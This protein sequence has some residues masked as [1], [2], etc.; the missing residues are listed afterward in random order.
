ML[1]TL[2][3]GTEFS[4]FNLIN[5]AEIGAITI[6]PYFKLKPSDESEIDSSTFISKTKSA[7][8]YY[9]KNIDK[10]GSVN[11]LY[12][13]G[14]ETTNIYENNEGGTK[15]KNAAHL[16]EFLASTAIVDFSL[17]NH[18]STVNKEL[19]L[20]DLSE[21]VTFNSFYDEQ[22]KQLF[23][24]LTQYVMMANCLGYKYDYYSS[25][26]FNANGDNFNG[27]YDTVFMSNLR[28]MTQAYIEWLEELKGNVR[29]LDL[30][31][32][33]CGNKP[34]EVVTGMTSK[35][36]FSIKSNY[37][38]VTARLNAAVNKCQNKGDKNKFLEM[39]YLGTARLLKEKF[40]A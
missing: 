2:R 4:N 19:G 13:L 18:Q 15:Q 30:F 1:K 29:S 9:E 6:L 27:L 38:L 3:K 17:N 31:K 34:F 12:Y 33:D 39:F 14:D 21:N 23:A 24:P 10:N 20:R 40:N 32:L 25:K 22:R 16:I 11:A 5:K 37:D 7:L 8:A 36:I 35:S 26:S 28:S